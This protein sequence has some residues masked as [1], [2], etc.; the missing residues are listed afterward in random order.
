M[1]LYSPAAVKIYSVNH[2]QMEL[3]HRSPKSRYR[4]TSHKQFEKQLG[5]IERRQAR[6]RRIRQ[7]LNASGK[8]RIVWFLKGVLIH[9]LLVIILERHRII[10][11]T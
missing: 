8:T 5:H 7:K 6:I 1:Y 9:Q 4:R 2:D 3:E 11:W 10:L